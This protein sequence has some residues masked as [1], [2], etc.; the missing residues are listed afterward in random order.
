MRLKRKSRFIK[1]NISS[2]ICTICFHIKTSIDTMR[3]TIAE[4]H[5]VESGTSFYDNC[6]DEERKNIDTQK[7][8]GGHRMVVYCKR[9]RRETYH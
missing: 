2:D 6:K 8:V 4:K 5:T 3:G 1:A 7:F 9:V